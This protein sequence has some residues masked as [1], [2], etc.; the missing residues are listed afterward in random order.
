MRN[1]FGCPFDAFALVGLAAHL[2]RAYDALM[3]LK[4]ATRNE[5]CGLP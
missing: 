5:F 2:L 4:W 3:S 1:K